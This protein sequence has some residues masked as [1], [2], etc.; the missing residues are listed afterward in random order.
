MSQSA[1][2][3]VVAGG[4]GQRLGAAMPK[5]LVP[6]A[7]Q[8][9][10]AWAA[11]ACAEAVGTV[12]VVAPG[13]WF[14]ETREALDGA[15]LGQ[16]RVCGGG[17]TRQASVHAG[18]RACPPG[19]EVAA[20]HDAARPLVRVGLV[21]ATL[22]ALTHDW[23]GVAPA[24][25]V[26]DT[27]RRAEGERSLGVVDRDGVVA[28]QTPQVFRLADILALHERYTGA[29]ETDDLALVERAG[30]A[31]R[32]VAGDPRNLK[33]TVPEDLRLAEALLRLETETAG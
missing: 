1:C 32:L 6:L 9:L 2:A 18:L 28:V 22:A 16:V 23:A 30:R 8:P 19:A 4:S 20:I 7:G 33:I 26:A 24:V 21:R 13:H 29:G 11:R 31:V 5:G 17:D 3:V 12:V 10:L 15:G 27:L 14:E 25:P